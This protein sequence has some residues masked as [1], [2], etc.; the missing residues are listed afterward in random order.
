MA[1]I[2]RKIDELGR[3][4]IP[5]ELRRTMRIRNGEELEMKQTSANEITI[6]K[7]SQ[8]QAMQEIAVH[9]AKA[10]NQLCE[11]QIM[12]VDKNQVLAHVGGNS[13]K[14]G[15]PISNTLFSV[16]QERKQKMT[17]DDIHIT[18]NDNTHYDDV[19]V[20][21][22]L[23]GDKLYGGIIAVG[24]ITDEIKSN[25]KTAGYCFANQLE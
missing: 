7:F 6:K 13:D 12:I 21:P 3:I 14:S 17:N 4:V 2:V 23:A 25:V 1:G 16:L 11:T 15:E 22:L 10:L 9:Y 18:K 24:S 5:K 19:Y 20:Y 8:M